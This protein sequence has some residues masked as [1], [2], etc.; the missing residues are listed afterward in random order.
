M[1]D[2]FKIVSEAREKYT[3]YWLIL[4]GREHYRHDYD[5]LCYEFFNANPVKPSDCHM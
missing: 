4:N 3:N 2:V 1:L 5:S